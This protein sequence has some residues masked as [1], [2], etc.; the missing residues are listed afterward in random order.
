MSI[1]PSA[2][3]STLRPLSL[4][5]ELTHRCPLHC[6]YCSNPIEMQKAADELTTEDWNRVFRE[7]GELGVLQ[8]SL[9]GGEPLVRKDSM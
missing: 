9:T 5:A 7:A 4:I 2:P 1:T 6:L 3:K 8:L